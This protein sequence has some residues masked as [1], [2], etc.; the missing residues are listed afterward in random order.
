M[1]E[2]DHQIRGSIGNVT[3]GYSTERN[4][5]AAERIPNLEMTDSEYV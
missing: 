2:G 3:G 5:P 1:M 4:A